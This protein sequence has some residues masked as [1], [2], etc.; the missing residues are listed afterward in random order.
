MHK[1]AI[2]KAI[3]IVIIIIAAIALYTFVDPTYSVWAPKC[4]MRII[5]GYDCPSCG[6]Q[7]AIHAILKGH[8]H[9][10]FMLNP[11]LWITI[12]YTLLLALV[13]FLHTPNADRLKDIVQH[14]YLVYIYIILFFTWWIVRNSNWWQQ[15]SALPHI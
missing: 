6:M 11:F 3:I 14:R 13:S 12:P 4:P 9:K 15:I 5:T 1:L 7:R 2:R 8:F 10:A